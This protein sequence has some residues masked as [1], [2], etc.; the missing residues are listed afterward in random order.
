MNEP[1]RIER[2]VGEIVGLRLLVEAL[3]EKQGG[4]DAIRDELLLAIDAFEPRS[5]TVDGAVRIKACAE[6]MLQNFPQ[7]MDEIIT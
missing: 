5:D 1:S 7:P 6:N 4:A 2:M 3:L